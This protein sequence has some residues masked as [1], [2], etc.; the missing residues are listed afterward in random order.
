MRKVKQRVTREGPL[1]ARDFKDVKNRKRGT[2]WDWKPAKTALEMLFWQGSLMIKERNNF[3]RLYDL[4]ERVIPA[5]VNQTHP[6]E[7]EEHKFFIRRA[8]GALGIATVQDINRY[9]TVSS[10]LDT[11]LKKMLRKGEIT[12]VCIEGCK[13]Q[14]YC[15]TEDVTRLQRHRIQHNEN[16]RLLSPFDN[17]IILRER[18]K[19]LFDFTYALECYTPRNK[20]KYGYFCL[21]ILWHN[22]L[23]GRIDP[24]ADR[25]NR[26]LVVNNLYI[27]KDL[28]NKKQF[29][30]ALS[31][32][33]ESFAAFNSC[34]HVSVSK[35]VPSGI[36]RQLSV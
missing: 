18:T 24:K 36:R 32:A 33:L 19:A 27:E 16:C 21:P 2:W 15:L 11:M 6:T 8:L 17:T 34:V 13:R 20:R 9:F 1:S 7:D 25:Q 4:T 26:T 28:P 30:R 31:I 22:E 3:Q 5:N 12:G 14:Y 10:R 29:M 23:V 35:R